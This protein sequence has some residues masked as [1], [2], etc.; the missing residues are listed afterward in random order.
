MQEEAKQA[1]MIPKSRG[2]RSLE[3]K[4]ALLL[5][6]KVAVSIVA[7]LMASMEY[8]G[9]R[10]LSSRMKNHRRWA[11]IKCAWSTQMNSLLAI[12]SFRMITYAVNVFQLKNFKESTIRYIPS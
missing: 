7:L 12:I 8:A 1:D 11:I 2:D 6:S 5:V 4:I 3:S 10:F 9:A